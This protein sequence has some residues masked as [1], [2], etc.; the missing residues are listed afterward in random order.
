MKN[1]LTTIAAYRGEIKEKRDF[2]EN[3]IEECPSLAGLI[4]PLRDAHQYSMRE[5]KLFIRRFLEGIRHEN[6]ASLI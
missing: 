1:E 2:I 6:A 4:D 5:I 3:A